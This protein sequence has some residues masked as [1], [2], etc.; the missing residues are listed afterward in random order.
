M[1][2]SSKRW[3]RGTA[4]AA[5][6][7]AAGL[8]AS[9]PASAQERVVI[10]TG[11]TGGSSYFIGNAIAQTVNK[12]SDKVEV[13]VLPLTSSI[14]ITAH[15]MRNEAQIGFV[16]YADILPASKGEGL[17]KG[18]SGGDTLRV[19]WGGFP[20]YQEFVTRA[21]SGITSLADAKGK[22]VG[23]CPRG[24]ACQLITSAALK[25]AGLEDSD[26]KGQFMTFNEQV[27]ALQDRKL[28]IASFFGGPGS[29]SALPASNQMDVRFL[30]VPADVQAKV[31]AENKAFVGVDLPA[32]M[33]RGQPDAVPVMATEV[34]IVA[35][36]SLSDSA[37]AEMSDVLF[38]HGKEMSDALPLISFLSADNPLNFSE[39][40][41]P[42]HQGWLAYVKEKGLGPK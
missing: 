28:D 37:I 12:Y 24:S 31:N 20:N 42:R 22:T 14:E 7:I 9:D 1:I 32:G 8:A 16:T 21:D 4:A 39:T 15:V 17:F 36:T 25:A 29:G 11:G 34:V 40:L 23:L 41:V 35:N 19:L 30:P 5:V 27:S 3:T 10:G 13:E 33:F 38:A 18:V 6:M 2:F 26:Y